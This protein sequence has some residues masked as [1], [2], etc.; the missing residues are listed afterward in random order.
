MNQLISII[1][2]T[3]NEAGNIGTL[4]SELTGVAG[5]GSCLEIIVV[6]GGSSDRTPAIVAEYISNYSSNHPADAAGNYV[7]NSLIRLISTSPGRAAQMN[8]G[9]KAARGEILLFLHADSRLPKDFIK[10]VNQVWEIPEQGSQTPPHPHIAGAFELE[11]T[12]DL[13]GLRLVEK[14]VNLRSHLCQL[15]YGDQAIF[16]KTAT[17]Q[18]IGG[19][20]DLPIMED[21]QLIRRLQK[22]GKIAIVPAPVKTSPRRWQKLGVWQTT[23]I[24]QLVILAFFL[25]FPPEKIANFYRRKK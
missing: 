22:L 3:Y 5:A 2:P 20:P 4:L 24:N 8:Q 16:L 14:L 10:L 6:D 17:F 13:P 21:F 7:D 15:P 23:M 18:Q 1:V 12:G 11:I 9:A 25:G 19:F